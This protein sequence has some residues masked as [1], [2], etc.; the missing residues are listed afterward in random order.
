MAYV[1]VDRE[2]FLDLFASVYAILGGGFDCYGTKKNTPKRWP[3]QTLGVLSKEV[4]G[5]HQLEVRLARELLGPEGLAFVAQRGRERRDVR[6]RDL[7]VEQEHI[8]VRARAVRWGRAHVRGQSSAL[9]HVRGLEVGRA[10][11]V[12][13]DPVAP[14]A[15]LRVLAAG[16]VRIGL[17]LSRD[18]REVFDGH[19]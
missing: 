18:G 14:L 1:I 4:V 8:S 17:F 10:R 13:H 7:L 11:D 3:N 15:E 19:T 5:A 6:A 16:S 9:G 12:G 2:A